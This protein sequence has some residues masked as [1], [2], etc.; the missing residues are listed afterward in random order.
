MGAPNGRSVKKSLSSW[1]IEYVT[2]SRDPKVQPRSF[3]VNREKDSRHKTPSPNCWPKMKTGSKDFANMFP[4]QEKRPL[5]AFNSGT[6]GGSN[7]FRDQ[8]SIT[9]WL[10]LGAVA[11]SLLFSAFGRLAFLPGATLILYRVAVAYLQATGWMH[12]PC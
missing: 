6:A 10:S 9:T 1:Y 8:L 12:N 7:F 11:Q 5:S 2:V 4:L 3:A